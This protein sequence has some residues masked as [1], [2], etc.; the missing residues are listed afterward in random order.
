MTAASPSRAPRRPTL[1]RPGPMTGRMAALVL[2]LEAFLLFFGILG[3]FRVSGLDSAT[4]W[5]GGGGLVLL[6]LVAA[7]VARR[8]GGLLFGWV[9]QIVVLG[10]G[11]VL[12]AMWVMG[13][14][15]VALWGWLLWVGRRLDGRAA[16]ADPPAGD[17]APH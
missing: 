9:V 3:A 12:P 2:I 11:F 6:A 5:A 14:L 16:P 13:A 1:A 17:T 7:A 15:F 4:V 8:P 10:T